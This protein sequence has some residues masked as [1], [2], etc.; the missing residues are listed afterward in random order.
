M[1]FVESAEAVAGFQ[2][3]EG[4][5]AVKRTPLKPR[6][7]PIKRSGLQDARSSRTRLICAFDNGCQVLRVQNS[8]KRLKSHARP[9][10]RVLRFGGIPQNPAY[11]AFVRVNQC[12]LF[13]LKVRSGKLAG[14]YAH[15]CSGKLE[16]AH[17]GRRGRGQKAADETAL[18]MC[19]NGHRTGIHAHHKGTATFWGI[20][21][22]DKA[23]LIAKYNALARESGIQLAEGFSV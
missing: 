1:P 11:L 6:T 15:V 10:K 4:G 18:P 8:P 7:A 13:G 23:K 22:L 21:G 16:A 14:K 3:A 9:Q 5:K 17:A 12:I 19:T 20:W 2:R